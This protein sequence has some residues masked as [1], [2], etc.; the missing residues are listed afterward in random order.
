MNK[1]PRLRMFAGPN[2]SGKSTILSVIDPKLL[3][4]YVNPDD[5]EKNIREIGYIDFN[6]FFVQTS[7]DEVLN[8]FRNSSLLINY[9]LVEQV[10][11]LSYSNNK[12]FFD[13]V[14]VNSYFSSVISSFIRYKLMENDASFTFETVMSS[15][16]KIQFL[17]ESKEKGYRTYLYYVATEDPEI[18][19]SRVKNREKMGGHSVD[20]DK[21]RS[22]YWRSLELL[23]SAAL[24]T[25]RAYIFDNSSHKETW[26]AEITDGKKLE[27]KTNSMPTWFKNALWDKFQAA[28]DEGSMTVKDQN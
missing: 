6:L 3:G 7:E 22:R 10:N 12:L 21:I 1:T 13:K 18:N 8:Y 5:M 14:K 27:M 2:G 11:S 23:M 15:P 16:D 26:I 24:Q 25:N 20:E 4:V 19:I 17:K 28:A 9:E